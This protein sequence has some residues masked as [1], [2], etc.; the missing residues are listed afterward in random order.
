[1]E[2]KNLSE[3]ST[4][5]KIEVETKEN[6]INLE[7][8]ID[9]ANDAI[10]VIISSNN[11]QTVDQMNN[12]ITEETDLTEMSK[13][14]DGFI[15]YKT[16][17]IL[18]KFPEA[19]QDEQDALEEDI[20]STKTLINPIV[21]YDKKIIDGRLRQKF[22][23]KHHVRPHYKIIEDNVENV[24]ELIESLNLHRSEKTKSQRAIL[25]FENKERFVKKAKISEYCAHNNGEE[26]STIHNTRKEVCKY[27]CVSEGMFEKVIELMDNDYKGILYQYVRMG[28]I[29]LDRAILMKE[30]NF[31]DYEIDFS[32][33]FRLNKNQIKDLAIIKII[34]IEYFNKILQIEDK[35]SIIEILKLFKNSDSKRISE[36]MNTQET[37]TIQNTT[38]DD[39]TEKMDD[40]NIE[41]DSIDN[42]MELS[43][44]PTIH[45]KLTLIAQKRNISI[46]ELLQIMIEEFEKE[47]R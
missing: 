12:E 2:T 45:K 29:N 8:A 3:A 20:R 46:D 5:M 44:N 25:A 15:N 13:S 19:Q 35:N 34:N 6:S 26:Y 21:I 41:G 33:K 32:I 4:E 27:Y 47:G 28:K 9:T 30:L 42:K 36:K 11:D 39:N 7:S 37:Q 14:D 22:C 40:K 10:E 43:I 38:V 16:H 24:I 23:K 1:M 17:P 18:K 31:D